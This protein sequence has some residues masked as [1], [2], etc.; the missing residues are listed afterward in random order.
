[1]GYKMMTVPHF[2][3]LVFYLTLFY[4]AHGLFFFCPPIPP[5]QFFV[6]FLTYLLNVLMVYS[7]LLSKVLEEEQQSAGG[8]KNNLKED[9]ETLKKEQDDL[10][11]L[12]ADQDSKIEKYKTRLRD[13]GQEVTNSFV[14]WVSL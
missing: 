5:L 11:V 2:K 9:L 14:F 7:F 6:F 12:L 1:M 13:L 3:C 4:Q 10:L 8:E